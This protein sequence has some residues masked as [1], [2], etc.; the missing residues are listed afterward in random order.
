MCIRDSNNNN[1][2]LIAEMQQHDAESNNEFINDIQTE[3]T[4]FNKSLT[5]HLE[6]CKKQ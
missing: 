3:Y 5:E 2:A 1:N 4:K 6:L